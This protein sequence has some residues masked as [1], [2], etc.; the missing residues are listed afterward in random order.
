[1][2]PFL[3][4]PMLVC[5]CVFCF[6]SGLIPPPEVSFFACCLV[7]FSCMHTPL[8]FSLQTGFAAVPPLQPPLPSRCISS[9]YVTPSLPPT[10]PAG[11]RPRKVFS[12]Y[13]VSLKLHYSDHYPKWKVDI[14]TWSV[15]TLLTIIGNRH[16]GRG[17]LMY[18]SN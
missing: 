14:Q 6:F 2:I 10:Q 11:K 7:V 5:L 18:T 8:L 13:Y 9:T 4:E 12:A 16:A 17:L 15:F 3:I 1:M